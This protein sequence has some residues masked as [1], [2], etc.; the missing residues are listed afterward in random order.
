MAGKDLEVQYTIHEQFHEFM[1]LIM[2]KRPQVVTYH[3]GG[4]PGSRPI[5]I[6]AS[7]KETFNEIPIIDMSGMFSTSLS[8]R[9]KVAQEVGKACQEVGFFYAQNHNVPSEVVDETFEALE[10]WFG[11]DEEVKMKVHAGKNAYVRGYE[12][13]FYTKLDP[14]SKGGVFTPMLQSGS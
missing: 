10:K 3:A 8:D 9:K 6:G 2:K 14:N 13:L 11:Q 7:A 1:T 5:L 4:K 12:P